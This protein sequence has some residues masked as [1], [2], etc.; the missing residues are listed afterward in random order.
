MDFCVWRA[1]SWLWSAKSGVQFVFTISKEK[2]N[3]TIPKVFSSFSPGEKDGNS[4]R[5][6]EPQICFQLWKQTSVNKKAVN[7][8]K[9]EKMK[10]A[11]EC[12]VLLKVLSIEA[13]LQ[14][15]SEED[16]FYL[17]K[18]ITDTES[19]VWQTL[20][21]DEGVFLAINIWTA[22]LLYVLELLHADTSGHSPPLV[23][24][25]EV[26][27]GLFFKPAVIKSSVWSHLGSL[28]APRADAPQEAQVSAHW[29][30]NGDNDNSCS[31]SKSWWYHV[32][33][34]SVLLHLVMIEQSQIRN[35]IRDWTKAQNIGGTW[36]KKSM[37]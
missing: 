25:D 10:N 32:F 30:D 18:S 34:S 19:T 28:A 16:S 20:M 31:C 36:K 29:Y 37:K 26:R 14:R 15:T 7:Q 17:D 3:Q 33:Q 24:F 22:C 1:K 23:T 8:I 13:F 4:G 6:L 11:K 5:T 2:N 12:Q 35:C 21:L 27:L 9:T